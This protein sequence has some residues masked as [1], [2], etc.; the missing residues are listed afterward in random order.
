MDIGS[1]S[2]KLGY[3]GDDVPKA[4]YPSVHSLLHSLSWTSRMDSIAK[5]R[6]HIISGHRI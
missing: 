2:I 4:V 3:G 1:S 5:I 6:Q